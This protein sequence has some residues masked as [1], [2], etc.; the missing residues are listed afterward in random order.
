MET[1]WL[2][3]S[4]LLCSLASALVYGLLVRA[5]P[6]RPRMAYKAASTA[7]LSLVAAAQDSSSLLVAALALGS[8]GDAFLAWPGDVAFL[9]GLGSFLVAHVLYS[10]LLC[11]VG[12]GIAALG[13]GDWRCLMAAVA[14]ASALAMILALV[15]KVGPSLR[16]P[17]VCY[18][19]VILCML[20]GAVTVPGRQVAAG[21]VLFASSDSLLAADEF[22]VDAQSEHRAW[23]Q[24]AVWILYYLGQLLIVIG[25]R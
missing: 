14:V 22:L 13:A 11:R 6:S 19:I 8:A 21:A 20:L 16:F 23:M 2:E 1:S 24:Y 18:C 17:I 3:T 12:G 7:L 9:R 25:F 4:L 10:V 5:P 15:P